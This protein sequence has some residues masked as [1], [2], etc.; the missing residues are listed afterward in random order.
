MTLEEMIREANDK[1]ILVNAI[2]Q[3]NTP[4]GPEWSVSLFRRR[5]NKNHVYNYSNGLD[6]DLRAAFKQAREA[7]DRAVK[8]LDESVPDEPAKEP[9]KK[10]RQLDLLGDAPAQPAEKKP[11]KRPAIGDLL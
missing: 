1:G 11:A 2:A 9:A 8:F 6:R 10:T 7:S 3:L 5:S 4:G